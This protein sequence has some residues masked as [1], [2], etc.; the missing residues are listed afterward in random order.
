MNPVSFIRLQCLVLLVFMLSFGSIAHAEPTITI[1]FNLSLSGPR[2]V[3]G[4]DTRKGAEMVRKQIN[5]AGGLKIGDKSYIVKYVYADNESS[6]QKAVST[7]LR[8]ITKENVLAIVGLIDSSRAI[9]A[10][11]ICQ[12]FQTPM[13]SPLST[14][15]KTTLNRPF[16]FRACFLDPFQGEVMADFAIKDLKAKKAAVLYD[17]A[18]AYPRGLAEFF[19]NAFEAQKGPGSV[20]AYENF[21]SSEK[22]LSVQIDR[23]IA[24]GAD[25]L[26]VPQYDDQ[27]PDIVKQARARGW[28]KDIMG[29]DAWDTSALM[30]NCGDACKGLYFSSHFA[31]IG[32]KGKTKVFVE[33]YKAEVKSLPS[34]NGALGY[35][36]ALLMLT[37]IGSMDSLSSNLLEART[38]IKDKLAAIKGFE[39]VSGVLSMNVDGNPSKSAVVIQINKKGEFELFKTVNP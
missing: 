39:G 8:L 24:S 15:P 9:P 28:T 31:A 35:D 36:S 34:A 32:A 25:V 37:A 13:I 4:E 22:D 33:K 1:G 21:L 11:N 19:K 5:K 3:A 38:A 29:G 27:V 12:S 14:N 6:P 23:I 2:K 26:F 30:E 7:T 17:I 20:V 18:D 16:V 10:G